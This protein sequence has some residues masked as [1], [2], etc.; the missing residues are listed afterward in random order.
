L[1][2]DAQELRLLNKSKSAM[3]RELRA[4]TFQR[5]QYEEQEAENRLVPDRTKVAIRNSNT[6]EEDGKS[7]VRYLIEVQQLAVDGT[8]A[9][10]WI[11]ARRYNEFLNM[12]QR[13]REKYVA[14]RA[15]DFP[16]KKLVTSLSSSFVDTR[17]TALEKY[18]QVMHSP[19]SNSEVPFIYFYSF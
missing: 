17:R 7:V 8:F 11:V 14:V 12:H 4:L 2:G 5:A 18:M 9:S 16:G 1:T 15:L 19:F 6:A 3:D 10:G 13:L